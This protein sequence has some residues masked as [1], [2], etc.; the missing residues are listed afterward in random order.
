MRKLIMATAATLTLIGCGDSSSSE[1][2]VTRVAGQDAKGT[3]GQAANATQYQIKIADV[4]FLDMQATQTLAKSLDP[5]DTYA[6][7]LYSAA[8]KAAKV[9]GD[10]TAIRDAS[11]AL[12]VTVKDAVAIQQAV[13][14]K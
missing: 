10:E 6:F 12:P 9:S 2:A 11:G 4:D 8:W 13:L 5:A 1:E 7:L 14:A 3:T